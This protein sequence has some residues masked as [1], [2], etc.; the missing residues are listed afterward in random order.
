[1]VRHRRRRRLTAWRGAGLIGSGTQAVDNNLR[2]NTHMECVERRALA[3]RPSVI[4]SKPQ[5]ASERV[6]LN[7]TSGDRIRSTHVGASVNFKIARPNI[8]A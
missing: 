6:L 8:L 7:S 1:M 3:A 2:A 5:H 4:R